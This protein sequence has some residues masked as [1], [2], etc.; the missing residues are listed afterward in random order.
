M[1]YRVFVG[2]VAET[3]ATKDQAP[4]LGPILLYGRPGRVLRDCVDRGARVGDA[5]S[6]RMGVSYAGGRCTRLAVLLVLWYKPF[7]LLTRCRCKGKQ[8]FCDGN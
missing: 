7:L 6:H 1:V 5:Q 4:V 2:S 8:M 3:A